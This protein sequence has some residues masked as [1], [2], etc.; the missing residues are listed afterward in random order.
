MRVILIGDVHGNL[1]A[2]EAVL[3][4]GRALGAEAIWNLG[5]FI[6]YGP[7]PDEVVTRLRAE[8]AVS[9]AGNYDRKALDLGAGAQDWPKTPEKRLA[10]DWAYRKLSRS[11]REYLR[12][13]P[14]E[15]RLEVEGRRI[16]LVHA[17]PGDLEPYLRPDLPAAR[18][19]EIARAAEADLVICGHS[20]TPFV[21]QAEGVWF[22][23]PG[24]VGRQDQGDWRAVY[25]LLRLEAGDIEVAHYTLDYDVKRAA[26][27]VRRRRL[28]GAFA[29]MLAQGRDLDFVLRSRKIAAA[30]R[31]SD[32]LGLHDQHAR[33]TTTL[34]LQ[35]F[36]QLASDHALGAEERL[37]LQCGGLLH[38]IGWSEG[39]QGHHKTSLRLIQER[40]DLPFDERERLIIGCIAR[41][42]RRA[43]PNLTHREFA[44]LK[45]DERELVSLLAGILRVC[46]GLDSN[47]LSLVA[48]V[49]AERNGDR[50]ILW[51][52]AAGPME[53]ERRSG[54]EK[55]DL[56]AQVLHCKIDIRPAEG[57]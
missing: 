49:R 25:A 47:H 44:R 35:L 1:P 20:H 15:L 32:K 54:R 17:C 38:D 53:D 13:L 36:D 28:P 37:W 3:T 24:S 16:L 23:N 34:A 56:L 14:A 8:G 41:Y 6:G 39:Q 51:C 45:A 33:H 52:Q 57:T 31:L 40:E 18:L 12:G 43:L 50:L 7:F 9:I 11:N 5:D 46:D 29:D 55:S 21:F 2:L 22:V 30:Q 26:A 19:A 42:H 4:H 48:G 27:A 10:F